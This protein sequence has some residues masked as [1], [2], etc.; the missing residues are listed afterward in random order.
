[1]IWG[2][3]TWTFPFSLPLGS[4]VGFSR[5]Q[6]LL[7]PFFSFFLSPSH[8]PAAKP[9]SSAFSPPPP[10]SAAAA[11]A[12]AETDAAA[13]YATVLVHHDIVFQV[14][15]CLMCLSVNAFCFKSSQI[16]KT[17]S[18]QFLK[19]R[20]FREAPSASTVPKLA[21]ALESTFQLLP[22]YDDKPL[23]PSRN[24]IRLHYVTLYSCEFLVTHW[25]G[26]KVGLFAPAVCLWLE[27]T[28]ALL[29][30]SSLPCDD[31][32]TP[33]KNISL[34]YTPRTLPLQQ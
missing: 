27:R 8:S 4:G 25:I 30:F 33:L 29:H 32:P 12:V 17:V 31:R 24:C 11:A 19:T 21:G 26:S 18:M 23:K 13:V 22:A 14:H 3:L 15:H 6:N 28:A 5:P 34:G 9:R 2:L 20:G 1:M 7:Y 10:A 16:V